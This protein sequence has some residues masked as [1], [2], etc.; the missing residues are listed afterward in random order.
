MGI[1]LR[2]VR[3]DF[4]MEA[5]K[6]QDPPG[7]GRDPLS[8]KAGSIGDSRNDRMTSGVRKPSGCL[9]GAS[10]LYLKRQC[11]TKSDSKMTAIANFTETLLREVSGLPPVQYPKVLHF[12][13]SLKVDRQ[14]TIP[15]TMFLSEPS[16]SKEWDTEEEDNAW[17][18]L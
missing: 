7:D 11:E 14:S 1:V 17:A 9:V 18:N 10:R 6:M 4:S 2:F 12:I 13:E 8:L 3:V 16:L 5:H 15:E